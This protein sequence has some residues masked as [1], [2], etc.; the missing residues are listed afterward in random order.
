M[1]VIIVM[2]IQCK[3]AGEPGEPVV[4]RVRMATYDTFTRLCPLQ[5]SIYQRSASHPPHLPA[6]LILFPLIP[7]LAHTTLPSL[8]TSDQPKSTMDIRISPR[9]VKR[10]TAQIH[11]PKAKRPPHPLR[12][13]VATTPIPQRRERV[14]RDDV[15]EE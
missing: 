11:A 4:D 8:P 2:L 1:Y 15:D 10:R 12:L 14:E 9:R 5:Q 6:S 3:A 7:S 13:K